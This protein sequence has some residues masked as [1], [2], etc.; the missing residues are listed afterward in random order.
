[1]AQTMWYVGVGREKKGPFAEDAVK[2]M[3]AR[4]ELTARAYVW[5][6]SMGEQWTPVG[7][8]EAFADALKEAP[9]APPL[10][11]LGFLK[12]FWRDLWAIASDPDEGLAGVADKRPVAFALVWI[13]LGTI[14]FALLNLQGRAPVV[15]TVFNPGRGGWEIFGRALIHGI[16]LYG[17]WF[18]ILMLTLGP[19]LKSSADWRDGLAILGLSSIPT[20]VVGLVMFAL[21]WVDS[22]AFNQ[23]VSIVLGALAA[24]ATVLLFCHALRHI[25]KCSRRAALLAVPLIYLA[26]TLV[27]ALL[28]L[29]MPA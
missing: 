16:V 20:S 18:A 26:S 4:G 1:M 17:I 14:V 22:L 10:P 27:Y 3:I 6:E 13:V 23:F 15:T 19:V 12:G 7:E 25:S 29:G 5:T 2:E 9:A 8:V 24:P 28:R 11:G 21:L